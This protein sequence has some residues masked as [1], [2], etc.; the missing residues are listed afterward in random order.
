MDQAIK[1]IQS[2][3]PNFLTAK[4]TISRQED[5]HTPEMFFNPN[6]NPYETMFTPVKSHQIV[7]EHPSLP[8]TPN[9]VTPNNEP[10]S[11][12][13]MSSYK[14]ELPVKSFV[15]TKKLPNSFPSGKNPS[16][17]NYKYRI[18]TQPRISPKQQTQP[19]TIPIKVPQPSGF[20]EDF[21]RPTFNSFQLPQYK[22]NNESQEFGL[23]SFP[24][25]LPW[26]GEM[27]T[28][29]EGKVFPLP[30]EEDDTELGGQAGVLGSY[31]WWSNHPVVNWSSH[32]FHGI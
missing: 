13:T 30:G 3:E 11:H 27:E 8:L 25:T 21:S 18:I 12:L 9:Q 26:Q 1:R 5:L 15:Q 6:N 2:K 29:R 23:G 7:S 31:Q 16:K 24:L 17:M 10:R 20:L 19:E 28:K 4:K 22:L 32:R 14:E